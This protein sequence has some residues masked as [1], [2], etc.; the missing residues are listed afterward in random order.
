M[1][2]C[3]CVCVCVCMYIHACMH[4]CI[5]AYIHTCIYA[6]GRFSAVAALLDGREL[7]EGREIPTFL[8]HPFV[9]VART[10]CAFSSASLT[11]ALAHSASGVSICTLY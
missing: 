6:Y 8:D 3:M 2:V 9:K 5:R 7:F 1:N 10:F 4:A 11:A